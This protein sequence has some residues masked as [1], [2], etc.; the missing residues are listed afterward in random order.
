MVVLVDAS[1]K[2]GTLYVTGL[3]DGSLQ[4]IV[5]VRSE[6][7]IPRCIDVFLYECLVNVRV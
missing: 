4:L 3:V 7:I 1:M 2:Y 5:N 6:V